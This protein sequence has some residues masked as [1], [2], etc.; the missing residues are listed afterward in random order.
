MPRCRFEDR[1]AGTALALEGHVERLQATTPAQLLPLFRQIA[2][3]QA[4]GCWVALLLEYE[5]GQW[6]EPAL[7]QEPPSGDPPPRLVAHVFRHARK[8]AP[9]QAAT[10]QDGAAVLK[11][12]PQISKARYLQDIAAI[13]DLIHQGEVYQINYSFNLQV[14]TSGNAQALYRHIAC[15]HPSAHAAYIE[16]GARTVLCFSPELLMQRRGNTLTCRPMKGT[17]PRDPDHDRDAALGRA[18]QHSSKNR[19]ENLMIVDLVR[20]DLHRAAAGQVEVP[21]LFTLEAYPSVWALTSTITAQIPETTSVH[22]L[23]VAL[24]PFGSITGAPKIAAMRHLQRLESRRRGL[25]CGSLGW[26]APNGDFSFNIA[27][28]TLVL[29]DPTHGH[30]AVGG[31]IVHDSNPHEEWQECFWKARLLQTSTAFNLA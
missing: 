7:A 27:I 22:A 20:N 14:E 12:T 11:V 24:F 10:A 18:L 13:L 15:R 31:G 17:A 8:T 28:R 23:L 29:D 21:Q 16:D 3:H 5:L 6:L 30:Y 4:D 25:Y 19:A 1:I 26:L 2:R 9:W